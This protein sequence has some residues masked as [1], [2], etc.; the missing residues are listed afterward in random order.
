MRSF[1]VSGKQKS[2]DICKAFSDGT[3]KDAD[4]SVFFGVTESNDAEWRRAKI[5]NDYWYA[6]NAYLDS[7]RQ[8]HF[9]VT[10]NAMQHSGEG[11]SDGKRFQALGIPVKPW[12]KSGKHIVLCPQSAHFMR[13]S[14][15]YGD[16]TADTVV[17]LNKVTD[18]PMRI[19]LWSADKAKLAATLQD[20]LIGAHCLVTWSSAA[21]V[22][23]LLSGV[24]V[25]CTGPSACRPLSG[26]LDD[27][28]NL[29]MPERMNWAGVLA[30][31]QFTM[32]ELSDGTAWRMLNA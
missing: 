6:D 9:R 13:L 21:A 3:P 10:R 2:S 31:N 16:W 23:A 4:G 26:A 32:R 25:I 12:R 27:P 17:A 14:G 18:R 24:P 7:T 30:D 20:D 29:P 1:P 19:R 28:E 22:T 15:Y 5:E 11:E 8:S